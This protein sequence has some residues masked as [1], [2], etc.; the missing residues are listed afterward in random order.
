VGSRVSGWGH[1]VRFFAYCLF[2]NKKVRRL[3]GRNPPVLILKL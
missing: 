2:Y 3:M 1:G